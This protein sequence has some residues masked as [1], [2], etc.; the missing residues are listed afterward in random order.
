MYKFPRILLVLNLLFISPVIF[1]AD[2]SIDCTIKHPYQGEI[3]QE[4][5]KKTVETANVLCGDLINLRLD[6]NNIG[7]AAIRSL[8][9]KYAHDSRQALDDKGLSKSANYSDQFDKL[10]ILFSKFDFKSISLPEFLVAKDMAT[11][12]RIGYFQPFK[13]QAFIINQV[14]DCGTIASGKN[15]KE[16]FQDFQG[17]FN[18]YRSAYNNAFEDKNSQLLDDLSRR[19]DSFLEVSKSQ[20]FLE[21]ILTT[22][23]NGSHFKKNHLVGPPDYQII[24]LHPQLVYTHL[25]D[26]PDG[27]SDKMGLAVEWFGVNAWNWKIPVGISCASTYVDSALIKNRGNGVMLHFFNHYALGWSDHGGEKV[28]YVTIDLLKLYEDK[29]SQYQKYLNNYY[30]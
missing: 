7:N 2:D 29:K 17:A 26:G 23:L 14:D 19:W 15:C 21:V 1:A 16:I 5:Y 28:Y 27:A 3:F 24:A 4:F 22:Y 13:E 18:P 30:N 25:K 8:L 10:K 11:G 9:N 20:T 6:Q 12:N